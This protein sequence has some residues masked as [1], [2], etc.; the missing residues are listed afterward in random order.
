M[1]TAT[2][3]APRTVDEV[4]VPRN[5][6]E[7]LALKM[8]YI[9]DELSLHELGRRMRLGLRIV[10]E[11]FQRLR[12]NRFCEVTGMDGSVHRVTTTAMGK[13]RALELLSQNQYAGPAP[14]SHK[15]YKSGISAQ[16][17]R[18]AMITPADVERAF[19]DLVLDAE[20]L[21]RI[22]SAAVSGRSLFLYG[23]TGT[24]KTLMAETL[25]RVFA[26]DEVF[27]PYAMEADGQIIVVHDSVLHRTID[28]PNQREHDGR[29]VLCRRPHVLV[30]GELTIDMLDLQLNPSTGYYAAP[31][32]MKANNG[33]LIIDDFGRQRIG[34]QELLNRWVVPLD[35]RIDFL[36]LAGGKKIEIPFDL[37]VVFATNLNPAET[38]EETFLRRISTKIKVDYLPADRFSEVFRRACLQFNI[39]YDEALSSELIEMIKKEYKEPLRACYP[40]DILQQIIWSARYQQ[41]EP[42]LD[43]DSMVQACKSYMVTPD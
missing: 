33:L 40:R 42:V 39:P 2:I 6:L 28:E 1:A 12:K 41:K 32:Q 24:G 15:E 36:T 20:T 9:A 14:V 35:R 26:Q 7:E 21:N 13:S 43:R 19:K 25:S 30:G 17:V 31:V 4:G 34:P 11:L 8:L 27:V 10:D 5:L 22:G 38:V 37:L 23:P 16:S 29:W 3:P 18:D